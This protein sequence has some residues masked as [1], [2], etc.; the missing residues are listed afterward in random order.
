MRFGDASFQE[1]TEA[2]EIRKT[3]ISVAFPKADCK[4]HVPLLSRDGVATTLPFAFEEWQ[5]YT[6]L[7][8]PEQAI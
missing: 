3:V 4:V 2:E 7:L 8:T 5:C 1:K 6:C